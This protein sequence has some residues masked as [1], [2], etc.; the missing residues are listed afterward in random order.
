MAS[1]PNAWA[2][3]LVAAVGVAAGASA[4]AQQPFR[5]DVT[6]RVVDVVVTDGEGRP[7]RDL[8]PE[9]FEVLED[10]RPVT[11]RVATEVDTVHASPSAAGNAA[12]R[13]PHVWTNA[14]VASRRV[15]AVV[16]DD[17][18]TP[19]SETPRARAVAQAFVDRLPDGDLAAMVFTGQQTGAQEF[20]DDSARL[21]RTIEQYTGRHALPSVD[22]VSGD[23]PGID[24][25][26]RETLGG[27]VTGNVHR[28][29]ETLL[30]VVEWLSA[31]EDRRKSILFVTAGHGGA[32]A[33]QARPGWF[34]DRTFSGG[35]T[36]GL[37][38]P[39]IARAAANVAIYPLDYQGL[40]ASPRAADAGPALNPLR[41]LAAET[42]G[43]AGVN[44]NDPGPLIEQ[45]IQDAGAYY[46]V[47]YDPPPGGKP[48]K[49]PRPHLITVRMRRP[50]L[51]ARARRT[52][53]SPPRSSSAD[54][55]SRDRLLASPLPGGALGLRVNATS[56]ARGGR[57]ARVFVVV[58]VDGADLASTLSSRDGRVVLDHR[59]VA[60]D[61]TGRVRGTTGGETTLRLNADRL[62]QVTGH[63]LRLF[64]QMDLAPGSYRIRASVVH[65]DAHGVVAGDLDVPDYRR[66]RPIV[67]QVLV[68]SSGDGAV[69]VRRE[70]YAPFRRALSAAPTARRVFDAGEAIEL[71]AEVSASSSGARD[72]PAA[73]A[74][75]ASIVNGQGE[76]VRSVPLR[77]GSPASGLGGA[78]VVPV[79]G[80]WRLDGLPPGPYALVLRVETGMPEPVTR[81]VPFEVHRR[82]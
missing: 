58:D 64:G 53:V 2:G 77:I 67:S 76:T 23:A 80:G 59:V 68:A 69:P 1:I 11:V 46:L 22:L 17:L 56:F 49:Q 10:G 19:A 4:A 82:P 15:F 74:A 52:S 26:M 36:N 28:T 45:L 33:A 48:E 41:V 55:A 9:D 8:A 81:R 12:T 32:R 31:I 38:R 5:A 73:I 37:A 18:N 60:T 40:S 42:G 21:S 20:T 54:R 62:S 30:N 3:V 63:H 6:L 7:A 34:D 75:E 61:V 39:V 24:A 65:G 50:G 66:A 72:A 43:V 71:Y 13:D 51:S 57:T 78:R 47:G 79:A 25:A 27:E 35:G 44:T 14:G 70:D 29:L 16:L